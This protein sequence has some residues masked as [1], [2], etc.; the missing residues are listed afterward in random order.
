MGSQTVE[1]VAIDI[2]RHAVGAQS[3]SDL[4]AEATDPADPDE[5]RDVARREA[6]AQYRLIG[7][8]HRVG[9]DRQRLEI[10]D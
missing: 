8:R 7:R 5:D 4:N 2:D 6:A 1:S 3:R 9:Y 10:S